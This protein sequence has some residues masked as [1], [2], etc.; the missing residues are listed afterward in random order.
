[1]WLC[2]QH[3]HT[4]GAYFPDRV[5]PLLDSTGNSTPLITAAYWPTERGS[6]NNICCSFSSVK[7]E[8]AHWSTSIQ[9]PFQSFKRKNGQYCNNCR[10]DS[11]TKTSANLLKYTQSHKTHSIHLDPLTKK[12]KNMQS[13]CEMHSKKLEVMGQKKTNSYDEMWQIF[14]TKLVFGVLRELNT[15]SA[16]SAV[17]AGLPRQT[18]ALMM[19]L[20]KFW[21]LQVP[22]YGSR[23]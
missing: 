4:G 14:G 21:L 16:S 23:L 12:R 18:P 5:R 20:L 17:T 19:S 9:S 22:N 3:N 15:I 13:K 8:S 1:M 6:K 7:M 10:T 11:K 2:W